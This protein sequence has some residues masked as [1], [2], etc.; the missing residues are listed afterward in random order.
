MGSDLAADALVDPGGT[1][2]C[3]Y[4]HPGHTGPPVTCS[5]LRVEDDESE[6]GMGNEVVVFRCMLGHEFG[7]VSRNQIIRSTK[8]GVRWKQVRDEM[9]AREGDP[10]DVT[11]QQITPVTDGF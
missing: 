5:R 4:D 10:G 8:Y 11:R 7:R 2:F 6:V 9:A 1:V 3:P